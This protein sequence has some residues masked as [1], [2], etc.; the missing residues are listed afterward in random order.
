MLTPTVVARV[1]ATV[2][3]EEASQTKSE[4]LKVHMRVH[5]VTPLPADVIVEVFTLIR[6][7]LESVPGNISEVK[8]NDQNAAITDLR[9]F[10]GQVM[11]RSLP[12]PLPLPETFGRVAEVLSALNDTQ[13]QNNAR[14]A[15][16]AML[17]GLG[18]TTCR[19]RAPG[20]AT[21][22]CPRESRQVSGSRQQRLR[23]PSTA[24]SPAVVLTP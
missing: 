13:V 2:D 7:R 8:R 20:C 18:T 16:A 19:P 15:V 24:I 21:S 10:V 6:R 22:S 17:K 1:R 11:A 14:G 23:W 9:T 5:W 4:L 12:L 3:G